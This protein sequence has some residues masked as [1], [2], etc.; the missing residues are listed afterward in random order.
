MAMNERDVR[1]F[2]PLWVRLLVTAIVT[3][4]FLAE[5]IL[6][7]DMMWIVITAAGV[8]YCIWNFFLTFPKDATPATT[9]PPPDGSLPKG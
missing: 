4:W 1:F 3:G 5:T 6:G 7:H 9:A 8:L 2:R